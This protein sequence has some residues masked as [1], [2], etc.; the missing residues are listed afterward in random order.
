MKAQEASNVKQ[1]IKDIEERH[2]QERKETQKQFEE[3]KS[4]VQGRE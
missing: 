4:K 3:Y 1:M 2:V